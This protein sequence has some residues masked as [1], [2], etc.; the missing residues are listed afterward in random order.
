MEWFS[1]SWVDL[2]VIFGMLAAL[3]VVGLILTPVFNF[4]GERWMRFEGSC[5]G[6]WEKYQKRRHLNSL[7]R[8]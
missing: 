7:R 1:L 8:R 6:Q 4:I 2:V 5:M 3:I